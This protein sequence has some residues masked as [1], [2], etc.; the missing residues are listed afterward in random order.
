ML[1]E[2]RVSRYDYKEAR[3]E[4]RLTWEP[5][6]S[7]YRDRPYTATQLCQWIESNENARIAYGLVLVGEECSHRGTCMTLDGTG[8]HVITHTTALQTPLTTT[9]AFLLGF[10]GRTGLQA[11]A[12]GENIHGSGTGGRRQVPTQRES[13]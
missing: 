2:K 6:P 7:L 1:A 12:D 11:K 8:C 5:Y 13:N 4:S 9:L 10:W 3:D